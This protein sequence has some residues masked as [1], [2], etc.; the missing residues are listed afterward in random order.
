MATEVSIRELYELNREGTDLEKDQYEVV[1][2]QG[3]IRTNR[4]GKN[5]GFIAL[6]DGTYFQN[7]QIVY[8]ADTVADYERIGKYLTGTAIAVI[9]RYVETPDAKQPFEIQAMEITLE[10]A[11]DNSYPLQKKRHSF[12]YL[13]EIGHLR[14]RTNTFSAVFR[15]RSVLAMAIHQ[16][17]QS[18]GFVYVNTP[19]ITGNDAEGAGETFTVT[20]RS[21]GKY[22]EDFFGKHASLTV[23]GQL[24]G[25]AY[26]LAFRDI[27]TFGP[28]F[29][30]ENSNTTTH[31][32]EFWMIEP[33]MA[34]ADLDYDMDVIEDMIKFCIDYVMEMCPEEM[35]FFNERIDTTLL[36]RLNHVR[37]S[38]FRRMPYTEAIELLKQADVKFENSNI[39]WG[40]DLNTEH[41]RYLTEKVVKGPTFLINYPAEIKAFYMRQ[42]DDGKT[43]AA[44]DL[45]VPG[46]G[47]LVGGSQREERL[48]LLEKKMDA[49]GMK[50]EGLEWYLDLRR[51]GGCQHSGFGLGFERLVMYMTG[52]E[53]IRDVIPFARTP[54]NLMF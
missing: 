5:V 54:K 23:S 20:T 10:G 1:Q 32:A 44:C 41:E 26:A 16:F 11:C 42:N 29:R 51:Y 40:M 6:N 22:E 28:T 53:N 18:Q 33:E 37:N 43:V 35:K 7:A 34:F 46:V 24:Q 30:A 50:K 12:E 13:R 19:I 8:S 21:D 9:G 36:E 52:M 27:Y 3:W 49:I 47:E 2:L 17:F 38:E 39:F 14:P 4:T 15:V 31:A 25:E 48:D 45:L